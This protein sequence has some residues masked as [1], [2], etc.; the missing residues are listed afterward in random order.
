[1]EATRDLVALAAELSSGVEL[2]QD[3]RQ[4][5]QTLVLHDAHRDARA[6]VANGHRVVRMEAHLDALVSAGE[7]LVDRVVDDLV[8]EMVEPAGARRADVHARSQ[9]DRLE[10]LENGDVFGVVTGLCHK[11]I[12]AQR[13]FLS[14]LAV[15]QNDRSS[16]RSS[17]PARL[18]AAARAT[19]SRRHRIGDARGDL[20]A[21]ATGARRRSR[22]G[23]LRKSP[24][25]PP[26]APGGARARSGGGCG[27]SS[28]SCSARRARMVSSSCVSSNAHALEPVA[29]W[30]V[31]SRP[32]RAGQALAAIAG[33]TASGQIATTSAIAPP[34]PSRPARAEAQSRAAPGSWAASDGHAASTRLAPSP[35]RTVKTSAG[36]GASGG[37]A[38]ADVAVIN[39]WPPSGSAASKRPPPIDVEL[40][41]DIVEQQER[42]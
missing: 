35:R 2:R 20:P 32:I 9:P 22:H 41:E 4:R 1:M 25:S 6:P 11:K 39:V 21:A 42:R 19:A 5:R 8:D 16:G 38:S 30:S 23:P 24:H 17:T 36:A 27:A 37:R 12:P 29:T 13:G 33:P 40:G 28:P 34:G 15:Y 26:R 7:G 14:R 31:P 18:A 10:A 3:D